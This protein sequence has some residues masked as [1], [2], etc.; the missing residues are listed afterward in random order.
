MKETLGRFLQY[1][2]LDNTIEA[3]LYVIGTVVLALIIKR[4]ISKHLAS[5][6]YRLIVGVGK[7]FNK[8]AFCNLVV[9]PL[10]AFIIVIVILVSFDGLNYPEAW[11]LT[12]YRW[13]LSGI[14]EAVARAVLVVTFIWLCIRIIDYVATILAERANITHSQS[15]NQLVV[16]FK[17]FFKVLLVIV[18]VL[19][20]IKFVFNQDIGN[21]LTG[22]SIVGAAIALATRESL[23]NLIASFIIFFD[24]PF[25]TGDTVKVHNF[26][27]TIE[28]IGLRSTR[29]RTIDKTYISVPNKQMVDSVVDNIS[30][31][32]QR[33]AELRLE[34]R[35]SV[36][37]VELKSL[38]DNIRRV[39]QRSEIQKSSVHFTDTGKNANVVTL[40][41]FTG[42]DLSDDQ[43]N[44]LKEGINFEI[45]QLVE[46]AGVDFAALTIDTLLA[47][48]KK[49]TE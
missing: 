2:V 47:P 21:L 8:Q 30:L 34:L 9:A 29:I 48:Q 5:L 16:F 19:L 39:L 25:V 35:L 28:K 46:S 18:G 3:Y 4:F 7:K 12:I 15:D 20:L 33:K 17:D 27:G 11:K 38:L 40:E 32:T 49:A 24:K 43:F 44:T 23:E 36:T 14:I 31:R 1:R 37:T 13:K 6:L 22:L 42:M 26:T 45:M 10:E 41:Y